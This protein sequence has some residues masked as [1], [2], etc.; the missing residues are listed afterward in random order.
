[1]EELFEPQVW[2]NHNEIIKTQM[3]TQVSKVLYQ[4]NDQ[5]FKARN[6]TS[7]MDNGDVLVYGDGK[8]ALAPL[9]TS[10]PNVVAFENA[11]QAW[12]QQA[13]QIAAT[14]DLMAGDNTGT[15]NMPAKNHLIFSAIAGYAR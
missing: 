9:N 10:A 12:D 3:L 2:V 6:T 14:T 1:V 7:Q 15:S 11:V 13:Q 5:S 8:S 4:T